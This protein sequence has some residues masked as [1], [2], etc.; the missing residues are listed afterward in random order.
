MIATKKTEMHPPLSTRMA[1]I[2][3]KMAS[4]KILSTKKKFNSV[5]KQLG[6]SFYSRTIGSRQ[7][8]PSHEADLNKNGTSKDDM[9]SNGGLPG[10]SQPH[11]HHGMDSNSF[12]GPVIM[13]QHAFNSGPPGLGGGNDHHGSLLPPFHGEGGLGPHMMGGPHNGGHHGPHPGPEPSPPLQTGLPLGGPFGLDGMMDIQVG[14]IFKI[15]IKMFFKAQ[16]KT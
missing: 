11:P 3:P 16:S 4:G 14:F 6:N 1:W 13:D 12:T 10:G 9:A 7:G 8:S 2:R 15:I 5:Q